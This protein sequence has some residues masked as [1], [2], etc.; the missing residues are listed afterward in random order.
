MSDDIPADWYPDAQGTIRWWDGQQWTDYVRDPEPE[1]PVEPTESAQGTAVM[2]ATPAA[3]VTQT[4]STAAVPAA[5]TSTP[6]ATPVKRSWETEPEDELDDEAQ[7]AKRRLW[8]TATA[9]GLAAFFL[10]LGIGSRGE[11]PTPE[12][13]ASAATSS[14]EL[15]QLRSDLDQRQSE[16]DQREQALQDREDDL[17]AEASATPSP[18]PSPSPSESSSPYLDDSISNETVKVGEDVESGRYETDGPDDT[19]LD[20][21]YTIS[22]DEE[23]DDVITEQ[24]VDDATSVTLNNGQYFT[25][26]NCKTWNKS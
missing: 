8:L 21:D 24:S 13:V 6:A 12:P 20:C 17:N 2:A 3:A 22:R 15:E 19:S 1:A 25:S 4:A 5:A 14:P 18:S 9:V 10:G 11:E 16:L 7:A 23:G 26:D